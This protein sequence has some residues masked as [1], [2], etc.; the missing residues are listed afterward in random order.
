MLANITNYSDRI[1]AGKRV[2]AEILNALRQKGYK[3][4]DPTEQQDKYDKIDGWWV[5][6]K[7]NKHG[8]QVKFRQSGDDILFELMKDLKR[9][10]E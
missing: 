10:I 3:I 9:N 1:S 2:E 7:N 8:V 5:D 4:E 6:K